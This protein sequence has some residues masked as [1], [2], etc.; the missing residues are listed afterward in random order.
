MIVNKLYRSI[1]KFFDRLRSFFRIIHLRLKYPSLKIDFK[2]YVAKNVDIICN[3]KG[4]CKINNSHLAKGVYL[5]VEADAVLEI[6]Q[7]YIGA[8]TLIVS[9][10]AIQIDEYCS[11]GEMVSIRDQ[12]HEYGNGKLLKDSG[13]TTGKIHIKKN[14]WLGAKSSILQNVE[15]GENC[16]VGAHTLVNKS[17][18]ANSVI[19]GVPGKLISK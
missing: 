11:I 1:G 5:K 12:N 18:P 9:N 13:Y 3:D 10:L 17:F 15:L 4:K 14:T 2:S 8:N 16:V 6:N 7:C 19:V